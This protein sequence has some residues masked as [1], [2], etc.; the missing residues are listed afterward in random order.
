MFSICF[1]SG[2]G[3]DGD[4]KDDLDSGDEADGKKI[5]TEEVLW[6]LGLQDIW[7]SDIFIH[8]PNVQSQ[9]FSEPN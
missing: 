9:I 2:N 6:L 4:V 7:T 8:N 5:D 3:P 1:S